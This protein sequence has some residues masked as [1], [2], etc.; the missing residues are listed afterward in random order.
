MAVPLAVMS[1]ERTAEPRVAGKAGTLADLKA[2]ERAL[3]R[4]AALVGRWAELKVGMSAA[5]TAGL[6]AVLRAEWWAVQRAAR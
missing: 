3:T 4:A 6:L 2:V 5:L 1:V